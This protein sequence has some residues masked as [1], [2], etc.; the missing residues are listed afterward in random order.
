MGLERG[1]E[2]EPD[3][4]GGRGRGRPGR[5]GLSRFA[6][7]PGCSAGMTALTA[8]PAVLPGL[9]RG[10]AGPAPRVFAGSVLRRAGRGR[11]R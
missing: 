9:G 1:A 4:P 2:R 8:G 3:R 7:V 10:Y 5:R 11:A 6:L